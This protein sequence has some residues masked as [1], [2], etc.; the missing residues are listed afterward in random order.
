MGLVTSSAGGSETRPAS[1][2][3]NAYYCPDNRAKHKEAVALSMQPANGS[4]AR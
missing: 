1:P 4:A 2:N 3:F